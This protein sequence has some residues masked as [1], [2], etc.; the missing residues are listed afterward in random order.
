MALD[1]GGR[2]ARGRPRLRVARRPPARRR[3][4]APVLHRRRRRQHADRGTTSSTPTCA[5]TSPPACGTA[6]CS[7]ATAASSRRCGRSS[8]RRSTSSS[9]SRQPRGEILWARHAD[10][11]PWSFAL[12]TGSSSICHSLRCAIAHRR[13][14]RPRAPR[15]GAVRRPPGPGDPARCR[16]PSPPSTAGPWTGTTRCS[17]ASSTARPGAHR[18]AERRDT[19][20]MDERGVRCVS[21]RPVDHRR[22]DLRVRH[23]PPRRRRA[24]ST[25][26]TLFGWA[27]QFRHDADGRYWTGTVFPDEARLPGRRASTYTAASVVLPPTRWP[28][29]RPASSLF[30]DH[31]G[32]A[33]AA[34]AAP[35]D[36]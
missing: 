17:A 16:T 13:A 6:G 9:S 7:P 1:L 21:D 34:H 26:E 29:P 24:A 3:L 8:S 33:P 2:H 22:R 30:V 28:A 11:T 36:L 18:L 23:G 4:L 35:R 14:P 32:G 10:G 20:V 27:Q 19:F 12:L 5:P 25:A 15:L 31:D